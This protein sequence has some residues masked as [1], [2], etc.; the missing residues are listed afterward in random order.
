MSHLTKTF[1]T[2]IA[3][4][5]FLALTPLAAGAE[6]TGKVPKIGLIRNQTPSAS[7]SAIDAFRQGLREFGYVEGKNILIEYRFAHGDLGRAAELVRDLLRHKVDIIV[8][9]G[10]LPIAAAKKV[11]S[12]IPIVAAGAGNLVSRGVVNSLAHPGGNIT[13]LTSDTA[14]LSQKRFALLLEIIPKA[15]RVAVLWRTGGGTKVPATKRLA[16]KLGVK[17]QVIKVRHPKEF[18]DAFA[19]MTKQKADGIVIIPGAFIASHGKEIL[20]LATK[21]RLPSVCRG[22]KMVRQGCLISYGRDRQ[23]ELHRAAAFVHKILK[24]AKPAELPMERPT[25]FDLVVNLKTAKAI[26]I[27]V[28]PAILLRATKVIE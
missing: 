4:A 13:G 6:Q 12:T 3:F 8:M 9:S 23:R 15:S 5:A 19:A 20:E 26:G 2:F 7:T 24:G 28:P 27:T 17:L 25:H 11:T 14:D 18:Q 1:V 21:S 10:R 16:R 22:G